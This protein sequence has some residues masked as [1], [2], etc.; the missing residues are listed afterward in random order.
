[1]LSPADHTQD[2]Q[3]PDRSD[4]EVSLPVPAFYETEALET[5]TNAEVRQRFSIT[6]SAPVY[7]VAAYSEN[8]YK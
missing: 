4:P 7:E 3:F 1:M 2:M 5:G 8:E 6:A